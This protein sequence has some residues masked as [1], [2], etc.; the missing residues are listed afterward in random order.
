MHARMRKGELGYLKFNGLC[1][2]GLNGV[3]VSQHLRGNRR[4]VRQQVVLQQPC[5]QPRSRMHAVT[6]MHACMHA[7]VHA[8]MKGLADA[9]KAA[10]TP[11][12][13]LYRHRR[14]HRA[15]RTTDPLYKP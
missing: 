1:V 8:C 12:V 3:D 2:V 9:R 7:Y 14:R 13:G 11:S 15:H 5:M 10:A 4:N 6:L